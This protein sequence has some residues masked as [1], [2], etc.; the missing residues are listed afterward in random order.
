MVRRWFSIAGA[1]AIATVMLATDVSQAGPLQ[2]LRDRL[3]GGSDEGSSSGSGRFGFRRSYFRNSEPVYREGQPLYVDNA[4]TSNAVSGSQAALDIRVPSNAE[5]WVNDSKISQTG[6][7][8]T[9][10]ADNLT[11]GQMYSYKV[12]AEWTGQ[13]GKKVT[14]ERTVELRPGQRMTVDL[15]RSSSKGTSPESIKQPKESKEPKEN[16]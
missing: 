12:K 13:G 7:M 2:R 3:R 16:D 1:L 8:R 15:N 14:R 9:F 10:K 4:V 6:T 11:S 5:V